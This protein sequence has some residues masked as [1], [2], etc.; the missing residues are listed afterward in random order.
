V[1]NDGD[2]FDDDY[3]ARRARDGYLDAYE[4]LVSRHASG[5]FALAYRLVGDRHAAQDLTQDSLLAAFRALPRFRGEAS[6]KTWLYRIATNRCL[7]YLSRH[8]RNEPL[9]GSDLTAD[10]A[11][12]PAETSIANAQIEAVRRAVARLPEP[13]RVPLVLSE[14]HGMTYQEI[15]EVTKSTVPAVRS[16]LFRARRSLAAALA[17]WR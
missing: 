13:Q 11:K 6:F 2:V 7:N 1:P 3:L 12:G 15:A 5:V 9:E 8:R 17:E 16:Q 14:Y 4:Q 10:V